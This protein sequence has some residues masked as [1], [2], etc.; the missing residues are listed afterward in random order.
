[1]NTSNNTQPVQVNPV[2][3]ARNA[4]NFLSRA[5]FTRNER[6]AFDQCEALLAAITEGQ[7]VLS[8][9]VKQE[10]APLE[11]ASDGKRAQRRKLNG[12]ARPLP[13]PVQADALE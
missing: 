2:E 6:Q 3:V 4:L 10:P 7:L 1:M 13:P 9:A 8:Q 11:V 5:A 12:D